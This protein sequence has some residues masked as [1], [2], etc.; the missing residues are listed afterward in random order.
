MADKESS[1]SNWAGPYVTEMLGEGA[2]V[3]D[4]PYTAYGG[5]LTAGAS[6]LQNTAFTGLGGLSAPT[7][8]GA[9]T[10]E[11]FTGAGYAAP[12]AQQTVDGQMGA[13]TP[14]SGNVLQEY[15]TPYLQGALQPQYDAANRQS[16]IRQL[17]MQSQYGKAGAYGGGRQAVAGAEL[18]RGLLDRMADIT[19][20]GY[21]SAF[22]QA[23]K[24][25]NTEQDRARQAQDV[26]NRYGFDVLDAQQAGGEKQRAIEA[27]G[28]AAD[29]AQFEQERDFDKSNVL[30]K[31]SLL[32]GMPLE[33]QN[34]T[35]TQPSGIASL[36][37]GLA[38][39]KSILDTL[40]GNSTTPAAIPANRMTEFNVFVSANTANGM[41]Q[42]EAEAAART[43]MGL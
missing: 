9:Y 31:Q 17:A 5:P 32:D 11:S 30:F 28:I 43:T 42:A 35:V 10:P 39:G 20:T 1:L 26:T 18:D 34:Y 37:G 22:E 41:N 29:I 25:F 15:M 13:Y 7:S 21:Q 33:T 38:T 40:S 27:Q 24:Q 2:A 8:M 19:G 36:A 3:A 14:A 23:Q 6:Q 16:Q 12:T 4:L